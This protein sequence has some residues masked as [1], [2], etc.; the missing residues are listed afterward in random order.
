MDYEKRWLNDLG[1]EFRAAGQ[2]GR[3]NA[4]L[5]EFYQPVERSQTFFIAPSIYGQQT[6]QYIYR[7]DAEAAQ[8]D[9]RRA[10]VRLEG[11]MVFGSKAE[12]RV[13]L[14]RGAV[15]TKK[16]TGDEFTNAG[17]RSDAGAAT[18]RFYYDQL[19]QRLFPTKGASASVNAYYSRTGLGADQNYQYVDARWGTVFSSGRNVYSV[20]LRGGS[21][22]GSSLPLYD[23]FKLGGMFQFSGYRTAQ[24][25]GQE[26]ALGV[27]QFRRRIGDLNETVGSGI[28]AGATLEAGN[29]YKRADGLPSRG[30]IF[31]GSAFLGF[32]T[33]LGPA[34]L[35]YGR[36]EG[37]RSALYLYIGSALEA[38]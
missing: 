34:Y 20:N 17:G 33:K 21:N 5:L 36:S 12:L 14:L 23:Q 8:F 4:F 32:D 16:V 38:F 7:G 15:D 18:A 2:L 24:L 29:V 25:I 13:G 1:G 9:V 26:Y 10:G 3:P 27:A 30:V 11:G 37:G 22:L 31:G 19:D 6:L 35:A 28:Y